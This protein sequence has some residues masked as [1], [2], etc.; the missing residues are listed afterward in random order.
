MKNKTINA[1]LEK[2]RLLIYPF[3]KA[4]ATCYTDLA[5]ELAIKV[6]FL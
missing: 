6:P 3:Y 5:I 2:Q 1:A 4:L